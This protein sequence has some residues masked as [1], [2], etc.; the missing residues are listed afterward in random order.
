MPASRN[1][2]RA[3]TAFTALT[4]PALLL[5]A[6]V[7]GSPAASA[8]SKAPAS[9]PS[10][11]AV[12]ALSG[13]SSVT[14]PGVT[15]DA[16][17]SAIHSELVHGSAAALRRLAAAPGVR[18]VMADKQIKPTGYGLNQSGGSAFSWQGLGDEAGRAGAG[19]GV[20]V[21]LIDTGVSDT[22]YLN[23]ASGHLVDAIDTSG[24][25]TGATVATS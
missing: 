19:A 14:V 20:H 16:V 13:V 6:M 21:A 1:K 9:V 2:R 15:V 17:L 7:A 8:A 5:S 22:T 18:G 4:A 3:A 11:R 12:V 24:L 10:G 23:R 25:V